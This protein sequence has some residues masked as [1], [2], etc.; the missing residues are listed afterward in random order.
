[1]TPDERFELLWTDYLEGEL[2]AAGQAEL[3]AL[4]AEHE[5]LRRR[6]ADSYETHRLLGFAG[7]ESAAGS[8]SFV[9]AAM[10]RLPRARESFVQGVMRRITRGVGRPWWA[11]WT[12][13]WR[14][15]LATSL[16]LAAVLAAMLLPQANASPAAVLR[17]AL[18][19]H[20]AAPDR[21]YRIDLALD[22]AL[23]ERKRQ[24]AAVVENRLWTRGDRCWIETRSAG[25]KVAW[26]HDEQG[27]V[28]FA[29][30]P[31]VGVRFDPAEAGRRMAEMRERMAPFRARFGF[32]GPADFAKC[33]ER[34][35][36]ACDL[37]SLKVEPLLQALLAD[38]DLR[39]EA[40]GADVQLIEAK[41]KPGHTHPLYREVLLEV[42]AQ[43]GVLRRLVVHRLHNGQPAATVTF[44]LI[45]TGE[46]A[47]AA[48]TLAGHLASGAATYDRDSA[49]FKRGPL[50]MEFLHL[51]WGEGMTP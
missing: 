40:Q 9:A 12:P 25:Q 24:P 8:A 41:W 36:L 18:K 26:G 35:S 33:Y 42:D 6:A 48:Y 13:V 37:C 45:E 1:M 19:T 39:R 14:Y 43:S 34:L 10:A 3:R 30:S 27:Q 50:L 15:A 49:P 2:D 51:L 32:Q 46:Q 47:D 28:W 20:A 38:F 22:P 5:A 7:Q 29:L 17:L 11:G 31:Q 16:A 21:C 4:L 23:Q 44:T